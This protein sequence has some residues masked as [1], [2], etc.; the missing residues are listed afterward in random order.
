MY[1]NFTLIILNDQEDGANQDANENHLTFKVIRI[2]LAHKYRISKSKMFQKNSTTQML[3]A[4]RELQTSLT[5]TQNEIDRRI[6]DVANFIKEDEVQ[7]ITPSIT[8]A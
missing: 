3:N 4:N 1:A 5:W 7:T 8:D 2:S 6:N